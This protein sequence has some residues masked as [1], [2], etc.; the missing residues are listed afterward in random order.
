M[1]LQSAEPRKAGRS[2]RPGLPTP[3]KPTAILAF[4]P[5][6]PGR[7][8]ARGERMYGAASAPMEAERKSRRVARMTGAPGCNTGRVYRGR[9]DRRADLE[10]PESEPK[11][12]RVGP[13]C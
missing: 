8:R 3:M 2:S 11:A 13:L 4:G 6:W 7:A 9:P 5:G 10:R 1:T 12:G